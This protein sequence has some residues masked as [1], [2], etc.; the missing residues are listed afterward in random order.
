MQQQRSRQFH[1]GKINLYVIGKKTEAV[2]AL[3]HST[4]H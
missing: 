1:L 3:V 4:N 2:L